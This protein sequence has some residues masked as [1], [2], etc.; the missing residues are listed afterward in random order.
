MEI[1]NLC[2]EAI[3]LLQEFAE[4]GS[5]I[6]ISDAATGAALCRGAMYG[7]AINVKVNTKAMK[8]RLYAGHLNRQVDRKLEKYGVLADE[9]YD[10]IMK[11][12]D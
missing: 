11:K 6:V 8:D 10:S 5:V 7:A 9:I 1:L 12:Y 4:K 3:D 2:C